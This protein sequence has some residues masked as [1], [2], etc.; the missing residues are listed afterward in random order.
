[1]PGFALLLASVAVDRRRPN[2]VVPELAGNPIGAAFGPAEHDGRPRRR[3][4]VRRGVHLG[5]ALF[6][7]EMHRGVDVILVCL[8][9]V[10]RAGL[11]W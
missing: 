7:K 11:F 6:P 3:G 10:T 4:H 9:L 8:E 1:M 2:P 5:G